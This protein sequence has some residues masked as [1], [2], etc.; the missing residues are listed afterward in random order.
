MRS[1]STAPRVSNVD[2]FAAL[3]LGRRRSPRLSSGP[4]AE[5]VVYSICRGLVCGSRASGRLW[6]ALQ[7]SGTPALEAPRP[8]LRSTLRATG[9]PL[10]EMHLGVR[11]RCSRTSSSLGRGG[12]NLRS[13]RAVAQV[14]ASP[15]VP[16]RSRDR[17]RDAGRGGLCRA[18]IAVRSRRRYSRW[19]AWSSRPPTLRVTR[20]VGQSPSSRT[21][22]DFAFPHAR[23]SLLGVPGPPFPP[24]SPGRSLRRQS[25]SSRWSRRSMQTTTGG[26]HTTNMVAVDGQGRRVRTDP[27]ARCGRREPACPAS[28][29]SST[30]C[31][32]S[33]TSPTASRRPETTWRAGS[34][35]P[36]LR[37][38][39][40][41][42]RNRRRGRHAHDDALWKRSAL[43]APHERL[44]PE[45]AVARPTGPPPHVDPHRR[46]ARSGRNLRSR[47]SRPVG[48][49][50]VGGRGSITTSGESAASGER[51][52]PRS[53]ARRYRHRGV[54]P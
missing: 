34:P 7:A 32:A 52:Q 24:S 9:V 1:S 15:L 39:G 41:D 35:S 26:E 27:L 51:A 25:V 45:E 30:T 43:R 19:R 22:T 12:E 31:W 50:C 21:F 3:P 17:A 29:C 37:R 36:R 6:R 40:I 54:G 5:L 18:H 33:R 42:A 11:S 2:G 20:L 47:S 44:D 49:R 8:S 38:R 4:G 23:R 46:R 53:A 13:R 10:P 16:A 48:A 28:T 14:P